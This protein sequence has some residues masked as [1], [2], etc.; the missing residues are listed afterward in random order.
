MLGVKAHPK[1]LNSLVKHLKDPS[2]AVRVYTAEALGHF[3]DVRLAPYL[4]SLLG[5]DDDQLVAAA[6]SSLGKI[7]APESAEAIAKLTRDSRASVRIAAAE[8]LSELPLKN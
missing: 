2:P 8:A 5:D 3:S 4:V 7:G 1:S 6:A